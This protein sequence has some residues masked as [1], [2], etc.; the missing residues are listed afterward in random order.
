MLCVIITWNI[1]ISEL[2]FL[3][4]RA[5]RLFFSGHK[6]WQEYWAILMN[7]IGSILNM[8]SKQSKAP[9]C[10]FKLLFVILLFSFL[11]QSLTVITMIRLKQL[12]YNSTKY[13]TIW[14]VGHAKII[15]KK[16]N[17]MSYISHYVRLCSP[18]TTYS[19]YSLYIPFNIQKLSLVYMCIQ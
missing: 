17:Y 9:L 4:C 3:V 6:Q 12:L 7:S 16:E 8:I 2:R 19:K 14:N 13:E 11:S 15:M 18:P 10:T 1:T 5:M